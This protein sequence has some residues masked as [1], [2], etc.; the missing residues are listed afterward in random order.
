MTFVVRSDTNEI[1]AIPPEDL[2][3]ILDVS[4]QC[5]DFLALGARLQ[6]RVFT[7]SRLGNLF[8]GV[9]VSLMRQLDLIKA[10]EWERGMCYPTRWDSNFSDFMTL[11][12]PFHYPVIHFNFHPQ[13]ITR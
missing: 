3:A 9:Y 2:D 7:Y 1:H 4:R 11:E 10:G 12:K 5:E 8:S 6:G 13:Q